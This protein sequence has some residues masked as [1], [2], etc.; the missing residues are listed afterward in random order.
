MANL[1]GIDSLLMLGLLAIFQTFPLSF[2]AAEL[3]R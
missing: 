2:E 1:F 3:R